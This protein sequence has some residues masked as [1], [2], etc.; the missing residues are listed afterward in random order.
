VDDSKRNQHLVV[1]LGAHGY[2]AWL[3]ESMGLQQEELPFDWIWSDP[4]MVSDCIEDDFHSLLSNE[5]LRPLPGHQDDAPHLGHAVYSPR[6]DRVTIFNRCNPL[7]VEGRRSYDAAIDRFRSLLDIEERILFVLVATE[8]RATRASIERLSNVLNRRAK[9][10]CLL[11]IRLLPLTSSATPEVSTSSASD[12]LFV[13][14]FSPTSSMR[15]GLSFANS[16]DNDEMK[17]LVLAHLSI[18]ANVAPGQ[19]AVTASTPKRIGPPAGSRR[20]R[21]SPVP[22]PHV[23]LADFPEARNAR[24]YF[25]SDV[26]RQ[27][28]MPVTV[29]PD[30][31]KFF[32]EKNTGGVRVGLVPPPRSQFLRRSDVYV[33]LLPGATGILFDHSGF[34][35]AGNFISQIRSLPFWLEKHDD[36]FYADFSYLDTLPV[37]RGTYAIYFDGNIHNYKHWWVDML[38]PLHAIL[39]RGGISCKVLVPTRLNAMPQWQKDSFAL[40]GIR[41][42]FEPRT[43]ASVLRLEEAVFVE[44]VAVA[45]NPYDGIADFRNYVLARFGGVGALKHRIFI[46]R[47]G[48]ARPIINEEEVEHALRARGFEIVVAEDLGAAGQIALF[49]NAAFVIGN[50]GAAFGNMLFVPPGARILEFMPSFEMRPH[51]WA[52][53]N[54][55]GHKYGFLRCQTKGQGFFNPLVVDMPKMLELIDRMERS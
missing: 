19:G 2:T 9:R 16:T 47:V 12:I 15:A 35:S 51:Y 22:T 37:Q 4:G 33:I 14:D 13:Y 30:D 21:A 27:L 50:H 46:K 23:A 8:A 44:N 28:R 5:L 40:A 43:E 34:L 3:L 31:E 1:S 36:G 7:S 45:G 54:G 52:L 55:L 24:S 29:S 32:L 41:E 6:W 48:A 53:A 42:V 11:V 18:A 10:A 17:K 49:R 20:L 39:V 38:V 26:P 25:A